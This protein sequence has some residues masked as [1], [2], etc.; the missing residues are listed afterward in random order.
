[1]NWK[2][3]VLLS[4]FG[5]AMGLAT[6]FFIPSN[7]EPAFW[8]PIFLLCA[9]LIAR[10]TSG[11][12]FLHG[13]YLGL[14]NSVWVTAAHVLF[15]A[16]YIAAHAQEATMMQMMPLANHP[17]LM[18][19]FTGPVVGVISG[20]VIGFFAFIASRFVKPRVRLAGQPS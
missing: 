3:I 13:V 11:N 2:L 8:L 10:G 12:A 5:L 17:R 18:M 14:A 20:I 19:I 4:I 15:F 7:R 16:R 9:F 6:V 1:M